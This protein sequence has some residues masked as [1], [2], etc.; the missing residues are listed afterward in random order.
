MREKIQILLLLALAS[1]GSA[2]AQ[3]GQLHATTPL[4]STV[5]IVSTSTSGGYV[6]FNCGSQPCG[7]SVGTP[8]YL[9]GNSNPTCSG[10]WYTISSASGNTATAPAGSCSG[11]GTGGVFAD[12]AP[13]ITAT[14]A[15]S[16]PTGFGLGISVDPDGTAFLQDFAG[17][18]LK[19]GITLDSTPRASLYVAGQGGG[20]AADEFANTCVAT[21]AFMNATHGCGDPHVWVWNN[22]GHLV[23]ARG[24]PICTNGAQGN[25]VD[26]VQEYYTGDS[27]VLSMD[28]ANYPVYTTAAGSGP[29]DLTSAGAAGLYEFTYWLKSL[30]AQSGTTMTVSLSCVDELGN[31]ISVASQAYPFSTAGSVAQGNLFCYSEANQ[32]IEVTYTHA[33]GNQPSY[34]ANG[35]LWKR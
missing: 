15:A 22:D 6:T 5:S 34:H 9:S 11:T 19:S 3:G 20:F 12:V 2:Y 16:P 14:N 24:G 35:S 4:V 32:Q 13:S 31:R 28:I 17:G 29:N 10:N 30:S 25:C 26:L 7:V 18:A 21:G 1:C 23:T 27:P 33:G 8:F